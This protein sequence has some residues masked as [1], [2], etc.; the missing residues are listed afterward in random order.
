MTPRSSFSR[1]IAVS[2]ARQPA[3][4]AVG[5]NSAQD[6]QPIDERL[7]RRP[8]VAQ[9]LEPERVER[10]DTNAAPAS[11]PSGSSADASRSRNSSAARVLNV[12]AAISSGRAAPDA[13]SHAIRATS[14]VVL[15][16]PAGATQSSGP[17]GAVA[18][19]RWSGASRSRRRRRRLGASTKPCGTRLFTLW[20]IWYSSAVDSRR[21]LTLARRRRYRCPSEAAASVRARQCRVHALRWRYPVARSRRA[22]PALFVLASLVDCYCRPA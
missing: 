17:G 22:L 14:V 3:G 16:R 2:S 5:S 13:T 1:E 10:P 12:I 18:A 4:P 15:P 19:A 21:S 7:D 9:D 8:R 11:T 20:L 6:R